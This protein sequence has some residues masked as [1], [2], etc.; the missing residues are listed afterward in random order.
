MEHDTFSW[1]ALRL[2]QLSARFRLAFFT[3]CLVGFVT[4]L[5]LLTN[6]LPNHDSIHS[7][8]TDNNVL[9]RDRKSVV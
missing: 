9:S 8:F 7:I 5:Y 6:T 4:H 1:P 2:P 3:A